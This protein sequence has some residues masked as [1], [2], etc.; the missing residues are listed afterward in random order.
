[1]YDPLSPL[2]L[3]IFPSLDSTETTLWARWDNSRQPANL[4]SRNYASQTDSPDPFIHGL[5]QT[6][7]DNASLCDDPS[8]RDGRDPLG[9]E[10]NSTLG[11]DIKVVHHYRALD[12]SYPPEEYWWL[13]F[14]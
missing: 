10:I 13:R 14:E 9:R 8:L 12:I 5:C 11:L 7:L 1:M 2:S 3:R 6:L 4:A